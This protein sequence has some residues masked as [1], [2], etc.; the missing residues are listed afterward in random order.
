MDLKVCKGVRL[1]GGGGGGGGVNKGITRG[2]IQ[3]VLGL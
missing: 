3:A 1:G 2:F